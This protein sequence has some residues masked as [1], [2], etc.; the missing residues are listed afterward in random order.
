MRIFE[1][2]PGEVRREC[3]RIGQRIGQ[4]AVR[5]QEDSPVGQGART[6]YRS[7]DEVGGLWQDEAVGIAPGPPTVG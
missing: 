2:A 1:A 5:V 4:V 6:G 7:R 3:A